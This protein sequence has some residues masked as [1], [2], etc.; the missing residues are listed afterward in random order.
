MLSASAS[1]AVIYSSKRTT[2]KESE[3]EEFVE[4]KGWRGRKK[5]GGIWG[6]RNEDEEINK[7][8]AFLRNGILDYNSPRNLFSRFIPVWRARASLRYRALSSSRRTVTRISFPFYAP[9]NFVIV[10]RVRSCSSFYHDTYCIIVHAPWTELVIQNK[11][12]KSDRVSS[13]AMRLPKTRVTSVHPP[14]YDHRHSASSFPACAHARSRT[15]LHII[16]A[17]PLRSA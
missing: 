9:P 3:T 5:R 10:A 15:P 8:E 13:R 7:A 1:D 12:W 17:L 4:G 16:L 2:S 11:R 14:F 6:E